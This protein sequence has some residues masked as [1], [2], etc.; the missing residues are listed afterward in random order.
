ML[1]QRRIIVTL[2]VYNSKRGS[3]QVTTT[4]YVH[5]L[6]PIFHAGH[7][8]AVR[9]A[10]HIYMGLKGFTSCVYVDAITERKIRTPVTCFFSVDASTM[11]YRPE[12]CNVYPTRH[13]YYSPQVT[14]KQKN[15]HRG[16]SPCSA[17]CMVCNA[18]MLLHIATTDM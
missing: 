2:Y 16:I 12:R 7:K 1:N 13:V 15:T 6:S 14:F 4:Q 17:L 8:Y 11:H 10:V 3:A 9:G 5:G 18:A